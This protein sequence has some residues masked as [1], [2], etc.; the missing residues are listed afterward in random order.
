MDYLNY[1]K[2]THVSSI[3]SPDSNEHAEAYIARC[4]EYGQKSYFTTEHG[5]MGDIFEAK[6]LCDKYGIACKP[7]IEAYIVPDPAEKDKSNYHIVIIPKT[8]VARKKVNVITSRGNTDGYYYRPRIS[9]QWLTELDPDDVFLTTACVAGL[10]RDDVSFEQIFMPLYAHFG[11][12]LFLEVQ[13]HDD[14]TQKTINNKALVLHNELGLSLIAATDSH[15]V[16]MPGRHERNELL[17][18]KGIQYGDEDTFV[19]DFPTADT[20]FARFQKQGVLS[21]AEIGA[22]ISNTLL[23]EEVEDIA[24]DHSIKM[25]TIYPE[26]TPEERM[27]VLEKE[28]WAH[29]EDIKKEEHIVGDDLSMYVDGIKQELQTI[30]DTNE[31]IHTADYF[32]F[33]EKNVDLAVHKYGGVLT[34]GGRGSCGS[35]YIC[36]MLC[37]EDI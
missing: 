12:N 17:K 30:R 28:V 14:P 26:L 15:Y 11:K 33:N 22:A 6:T 24:L 18:G 31:E 3:F 7:G 19:L 5:S 36:S 35:F 2:H 27:D 20:L 34:R 10:L 21:D 23:F 1:H 25:P 37:F 8:N 4:A 16:D 32:L 9:P 13:S 29:F